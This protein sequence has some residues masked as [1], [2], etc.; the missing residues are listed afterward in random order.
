MSYEAP[1]NE[2]GN[3]FRAVLANGAYR[4]VLAADAVSSAGEVLFWVALMVFLLEQPG[5]AALLAVAVAARVVPR[6]AGGPLANRIVDRIDR[7]NLLIGLDLARAAL[8]VLMTWAAETGRSPVTLIVIVVTGCALSLPYRPALTSALPQ[9]VGERD[10]AAANALI[11]AVGQLSSLSGPLLAALLLALG[12][13]SWAFAANG[14][15][16]AASAVLLWPVAALATRAPTRGTTADL[17]WR[18]QIQAGIA[19]VKA[20]TGLS[21]LFGVVAVV[22]MLRGFELVLHVKATRDV[23]GLDPAGFGLI[24]AALGGGAL[25]AGPFTSRIAGVRRPGLGLLAALLVGAVPLA[26]LAALQ[27]IWVAMLVLAIEGAA[28]VS[29]EVLALTLMQRLCRADELGLVLSLQSM[30]SSGAKLAG[31]ALA[32]MFVFAIGIRGSLVAVAVIVLLLAGLM[33]SRVVHLGA[34]SVERRRELEPF[35]DGLRHLGVFEGAALPAIERLAMHVE[36]EAMTPGTV[37]VREGDD[38]D[39]FYVV[40]EGQFGV[41]VRGVQVNELGPDDWFGEL[42]LMRRAPRNA[43]V[44]ATTDAVVWRIPGDEFLN[45]VTSTPS[46]PEPL[47]EGMAVRLARTDGLFGGEIDAARHAP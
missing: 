18:E 36:V 17:A 19:S 8:M 10:L 5:G 14:V 26:L 3:A 7:R 44:T 13:P 15:S 20:Q 11:N 32:P 24:S 29:F 43:T 47:I 22:M 6:V 46:L 40:H 30:S 42:G 31:S 39:D 34:S 16:Y 9:V 2:T 38:A 33:G 41:T 35:I 23:L 12:G 25:A 37:A 27:S 4:R 45:A 1:S 21:V 28:M